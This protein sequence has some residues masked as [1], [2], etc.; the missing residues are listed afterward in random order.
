VRGCDTQPP[1]YEKNTTVTN[2]F[3]PDSGL[4]TSIGMF[5]TLVYYTKILFWIITPTIFLEHPKLPMG[6]AR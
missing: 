3:C 1:L 2:L 4:V 5:N 6:T